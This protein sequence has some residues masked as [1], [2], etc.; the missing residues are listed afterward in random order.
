MKR[1]DVKVFDVEVFRQSVEEAD[2]Q[3]L[4]HVMTNYKF[5]DWEFVANNCLLSW[6]ESWPKNVKFLYQDFLK[7]SFFKNSFT[8]KQASACKF[9]N[10][11][12]GPT[13][14]IGE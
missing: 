10:K 5:E 4:M 14:K 2:W 9:I 13:P 8:D 3:D 7:N 1:K 11:G 12:F 6:V